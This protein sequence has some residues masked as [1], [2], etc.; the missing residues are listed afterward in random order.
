MTF[1]FTRECENLERVFAVESGRENGRRSIESSAVPRLS[2]RL[3]RAL[4]SPW[5]SALD[6]I[7][8]ES[9]HRDVS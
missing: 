4:E 8:T 5:L 3:P 7:S 1:P 9:P 6:A 2:H